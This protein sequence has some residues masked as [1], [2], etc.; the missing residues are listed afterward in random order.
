MRSGDTTRRCADCPIAVFSISARFAPSESC[1]ASPVVFWNGRIASDNSG[2]FEALT[3]LDGPERNTPDFSAQPPPTT[4][5]ASEPMAIHF[6]GGA[7]LGGTGIGIAR[8]A[9]VGREP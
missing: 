5:T 4:A 8:E 1:D 7:G 9:S 2:P 6:H 3:A